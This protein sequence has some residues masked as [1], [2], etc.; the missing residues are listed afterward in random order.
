MQ[1]MDVPVPTKPIDLEE[2]G[3]KANVS[4]PGLH[5]SIWGHI[6]MTL[7]KDMVFQQLKHKAVRIHKHTEL[8]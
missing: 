7:C 1:H 5:E 3:I 6:S 8:I 2:P 4:W